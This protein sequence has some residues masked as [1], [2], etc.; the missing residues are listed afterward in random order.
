[1]E[2]RINKVVLIIIVL[3]VI[4][5]GYF[6]LRGRYQAPAP[7]VP[8]P[9]AEKVTVPEEKAT[10]PEIREIAVSGTEYSFSPS[11]ITLSAGE[12]VKITFRN[13]GRIVHNFVIRDLGISTKTIGPGQTDSFEFTAPVS[14]S[15]TFTCSVP[16][17]ATAGMAG[18][19]IVE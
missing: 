11:S 19:L 10:L 14:G 2:I 15:Y 6:L 13:D 4:I 3:V 9:P 18:D 12:R 8:T 1:M 16:G 17:H 7:T 5:G